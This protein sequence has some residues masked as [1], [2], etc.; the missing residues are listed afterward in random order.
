MKIFSTLA[1]AAIL[2]GC[3]TAY[4]PLGVTGGYSS[5]RLDTNVFQ[6]DFKGN[7]YVDR[8]KANDFA[9][10][11]SA[12][13]ALKNGYKYFFIVKTFEYSKDSSCT[14]P[15]TETTHIAVNTYGSVYS[16][17]INTNFYGNTYGPATTAI[18]GV[19]PCTASKPGTSYT[20]VCFENEPEGNSF[21]A[22]SV[23]RRLK[24]KYGLLA[25][26]P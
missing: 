14:A 11:R 19:S 6:V 24:E 23:A 2:A 26:D 4:K 12:E 16:Y 5:S 9:L 22:E 10:L 21:N 13:L 20:I 7:V 17:G 25:P 8:D 18:S 15:A 1:I 3:A